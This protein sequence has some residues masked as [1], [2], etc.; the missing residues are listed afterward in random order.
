MI[1]IHLGAWKK[2]SLSMKHNHTLAITV[3]LKLVVLVTVAVIVNS[4]PFIATVAPARLVVT[5]TSSP[6]ESLTDPRKVNSS[7][8][9]I[10]TELSAVMDGAKLPAK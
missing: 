5:V 1:H 3:S 4:L 2:D 6:L 7:P 10:N 8:T 9:V